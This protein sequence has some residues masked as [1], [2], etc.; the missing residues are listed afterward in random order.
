MNI[1]NYIKLIFYP[2]YATYLLYSGLNSYVKNSKMSY[3]SVYKLLISMLL[4][5]LALGVL[6]NMD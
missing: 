1:K 4:Y 5:A 3:K 6:F 2:I